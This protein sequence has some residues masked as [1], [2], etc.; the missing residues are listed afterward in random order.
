M[1]VFIS[2]IKS[3]LGWWFCIVTS[4][5]QVLHLV[6]L[7]SLDIA[8]S[9]VSEAYVE[10]QARKRGTRHCTPTLL[11]FRA[12]SWGYTCHFCSHPIDQR[13]Y[14]CTH[15]L[16]QGKLGMWFIL[17]NLAKNS[18]TIEEGLTSIHI[19]KVF[20]INYLIGLQK[21]CSYLYFPLLLQHRTISEKYPAKLIT[22]ENDRHTAI[23]A[24][25]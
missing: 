17:G 19:F 3:E 12:Q 5:I 13:T 21:D 8:L 23:F 2:G 6:A 25:S 15:S 11:P 20:D 16:L 24:F 9:H 14:S 7:P 18:M 4:K 1:S 10:Y 22:Q